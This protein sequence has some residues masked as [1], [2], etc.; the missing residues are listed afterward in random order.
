MNATTNN[1]PN[2]F[3]ITGKSSYIRGRPTFMH[4]GFD[5]EF[6]D[7]RSEYK[8]VIFFAMEKDKVYKNC[9]AA[10]WFRQETLGL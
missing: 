1:V 4:Y 3:I 8:S 10:K 9:Y 7:W 2:D 5:L 6:W